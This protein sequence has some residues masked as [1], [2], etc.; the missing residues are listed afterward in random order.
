MTA[1]FANNYLSPCHSFHTLIYKF[2]HQPHQLLICKKD[3]FWNFNDTNFSLTD[4]TEV[5]FCT[6]LNVKLCT[7][8]FAKVF[9]CIK[10]HAL[11][12]NVMVIC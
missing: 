1:L 6:F 3:F 12:R 2:L 4:R 7:Y 5:F 8:N 9:E 11:I 10:V